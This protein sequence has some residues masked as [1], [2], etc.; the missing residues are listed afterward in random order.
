M[1]FLKENQT[2]GSVSPEEAE[3][4]VYLGGWQRQECGL[5][6]RGGGIDLGLYRHEG[7]NGIAEKGTWHSSQLL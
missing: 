3:I 4:L 5:N 7:D 6:Q 2:E 1:D